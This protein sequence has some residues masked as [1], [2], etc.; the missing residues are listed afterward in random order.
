M[1]SR[2]PI[3]LFAL[4]FLISLLPAQA[5]S[6]A[7][8]QKKAQAGDY[9]AQFAL[10]QAYVEGKK[11]PRDYVKSTEWLRKSADQDYAPAEVTLGAFYESGIFK[12]VPGFNHPNP[13]EAAKWYRKAARQSQDDPRPAQKAQEDLSQL[14]AKGLISKQ[15]ADW[16]GPDP[17]EHVAKQTKK[18]PSPFSL[19]E[20]E[21]GLTGGI[22]SK[23]MATLVSTY[24]VNFP[25]TATVR[26]RLAGDGAD[27]N[28]L[29]TIS[30]SRQ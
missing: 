11:V 19:T 22:T 1:P 6:I 7:S 26:K 23:R 3:P 27:D 10:A 5:E 8:L 12:E 16:H 13:H 4:T 18:G 30:A 15:E 2:Q 21:N 17:D 29:A 25:L 24:G 14:L 9:K 20:V 28:L